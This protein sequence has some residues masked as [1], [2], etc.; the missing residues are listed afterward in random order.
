MTRAE[1]LLAKDR[2]TYA[3][4]PTL[5][6]RLWVETWEHMVAEEKRTGRDILK[7]DAALL[8]R[9]LDSER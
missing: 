6:M 4:R 5:G 7:D 9:E 3:K 2:A 1:E 8:R